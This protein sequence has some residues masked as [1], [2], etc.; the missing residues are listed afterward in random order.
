MKVAL[1]YLLGEADWDSDFGKTV[2]NV[3]GDNKG[4]YFPL[5]PSAVLPVGTII[6]LTEKKTEQSIQLVVK[7]LLYEQDQNLLTLYVDVHDEIDMK[8]QD[9]ARYINEC[10]IAGIAIEEWAGKI[11]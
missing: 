11:P 3:L 10:W 5:D 1:C 2:V 9:F 4:W 6:D 7:K 8:P